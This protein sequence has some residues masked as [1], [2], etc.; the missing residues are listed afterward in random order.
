[1]TLADEN[2]RC[3]ACRNVTYGFPVATTDKAI[4]TS[5]FIALWVS[6]EEAGVF[7]MMM[8]SYDRGIKLAVLK[9]QVLTCWFLF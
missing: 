1:M 3:V 9:M 6:V 5:S 4:M 7:V 2:Q 8:V